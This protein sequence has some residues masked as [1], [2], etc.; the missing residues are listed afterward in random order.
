MKL[1]FFLGAFSII[2]GTI[3]TV[4]IVASCNSLEIQKKL[5]DFTVQS[6]LITRDFYV[7]NPVLSRVTKTW[8]IKRI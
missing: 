8:I 6:S 7:A 3:Y 4:L 1:Q 2:I 5:Q